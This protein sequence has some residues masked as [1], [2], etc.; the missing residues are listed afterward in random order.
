MRLYSQN[1]RRRNHEKNILAL[2]L[3]VVTISIACLIASPA[4]SA[5]Q[6][7]GSQSVQQQRIANGV[8]SGELTR[9]ELVQLRNEQRQVRRFARHARADGHVDKW[10]HHKLSNMR[11]KASRH[12][13]KAK[14]NRATYVS[15]K[16]DF[17]RPNARHH[18]RGNRATRNNYGA[19]SGTI[20]HPGM[21]VAWNIGLH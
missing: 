7:S 12:I 8:R 10:E 14:H 4:W 1:Q 11:Q 3:S 16:R 9:H 19:F 13:Y 17:K 18:E 6:Y 2:A 15:C 5:G 21:S 20:I